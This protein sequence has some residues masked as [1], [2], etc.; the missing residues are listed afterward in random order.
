MLVELAIGDAYGAGFEYVSGSII[1]RHNDLSAYVQHPRHKIYPGHYTDDTQMS[2]A[3]AEAIVERIPWTPENLANKFV[4]SFRR[5]P[6]EG[7][8]QNFYDFLSSLQDGKQFLEYIQPN[9]DKSGAAMRSAPIGVFPQIEEVINRSKIQ[10]AITHN[11]PDGINAAIAAALATHYFLHHLGSKAN[12]GFF[13]EK[14]VEGE[15]SKPWKGKVGAKG[16]MSVRAAITAICQSHSMSNL[17]KTCINFTG[18]VDT[19]AAIA[20]SAAS[21]SI[22]ISQ[23]LPCNLYQDLEH[24]K[25]GYDFLDELNSKLL[26]LI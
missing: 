15:W 10:A 18:D 9:S 12:L 3:V 16:W 6:R 17:L 8:S 11:T 1:K 20:L 26:S 19:V 13:L 23:D 2:I 25:F 21:C 14:Y 24:G 5:D 22:E 7:Y 4:N